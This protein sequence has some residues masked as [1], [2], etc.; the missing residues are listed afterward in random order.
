MTWSER[1]KAWMAGSIAAIGSIMPRVPKNLKTPPKTKPKAKPKEKP[2]KNKPDPSK[3][4]QKK[5]DEIPKKNKTDDVADWLE[6]I[7]ESI[8]GKPM[9][10][11]VKAMKSGNG[12]MQLLGAVAL[13]FILIMLFRKE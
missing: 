7:A 8:G 2:K 11:A 6:D 10:G 12:L 9:K 1:V 3:P 5:P 13:F 4:T